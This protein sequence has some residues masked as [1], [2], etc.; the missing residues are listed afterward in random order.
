MPEPETI[1]GA[2]LIVPPAEVAAAWDRLAGAL[3]PVIDAAPTTLLGVLMGGLVPLAELSRRLSGDFVIDACQASR[4]RGGLRGGEPEWLMPP[5][6]PLSGRQVV[7]VDD[8]YDE[9]VTLEFVARQLSD[10]G[11]AGVVTAVLVR[12]S[13][14]RAV[15]GFAPDFVGLVVPDRYVFGCGMDYRHR[16]RHLRGIH[17]LPPGADGVEPPP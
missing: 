5:Q 11:A 2:E 6:Y 1:A 7:V 13:H 14:S 3:Q 15:P 4:Y 12:K 10:A 17:A 16:F 9:G 8:I